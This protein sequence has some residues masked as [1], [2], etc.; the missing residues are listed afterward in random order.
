M[1]YWKFFNRQYDNC[2]SGGNPN[3]TQLQTINNATT[4]TVFV[5]SKAVD[6]TGTRAAIS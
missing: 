3:A 5:P 1:D 2:S 6:L 4:G